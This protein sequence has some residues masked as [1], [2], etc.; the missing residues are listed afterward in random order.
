MART[1]RREPMASFN[2]NLSDDLASGIAARPGWTALVMPSIPLGSGTA[3]EIGE[4]YSFPGSCTIL[5]TTLRAIFMDLADQLDQQGFRWIVAVHGHGDPAHNRM[6]DQAGDY[7][8]NTYG[9]EMVN[10]FGY[11]WAM[12][13]KEFRTPEQQLEDGLAEHAT[14]TE[15]SWILALKPK[16]VAPDFKAAR[17]YT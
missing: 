2:Q 5:P 6:L 1:C 12:K 4:K 13:L 15:T 9:G 16:A 17:P 7:F 3:N 10:L 14:M 8:H 11:L